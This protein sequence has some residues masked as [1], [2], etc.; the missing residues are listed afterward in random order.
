M[1]R[2]TTSPLD[3][4]T[5][6]I[7]RRQ[8]A[9]SS[10]APAAAPPPAAL[11]FARNPPPRPRGDAGPAPGKH[12][13]DSGV[14]AHTRF[15]SGARRLAARSQSPDA[16]RRYGQ[17][18]DQGASAVISRG[19]DKPDAPA[20]AGAAPAS[21]AAAPFAAGSLREPASLAV[22]M[23]APPRGPV[24]TDRLDCATSRRDFQSVASSYRS[25]P[26]QS[27]MERRLQSA[28]PSPKMKESCR[29]RVRQCS[30]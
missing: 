24:R 21:A 11:L 23:A 4:G 19:C 12:A 28:M 29:M 1:Q 9:S 27:L 5:S 18:V 26:G 7:R 13:R 17:S 22:M 30:L 20:T 10:A 8:G 16:H 25:T 15:R 6:R 3:A 14:P 2:T